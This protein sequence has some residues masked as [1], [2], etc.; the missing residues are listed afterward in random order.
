MTS[1]NL[2]IL[3]MLSTRLWWRELTRHT[4][5]VFLS[6]K[7]VSAFKDYFGCITWMTKG[8]K[9]DEGPLKGKWAFHLIWYFKRSGDFKLQLHHKMWKSWTAA[10]GKIHCVWKVTCQ[11]NRYFWLARKDS[12]VTKVIPVPVQR[13]YPALVKTFPFVALNVFCWWLFTRD[14]FCRKRMLAGNVANPEWQ[15]TRNTQFSSP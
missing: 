5:S 12:I 4:Q 1:G 8:W 6:Q 11:S 9:F 7:L 14:C 10:S 13:H 3:Q 15:E 2:W